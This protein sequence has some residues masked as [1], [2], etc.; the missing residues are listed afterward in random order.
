MHK[1]IGTDMSNMYT[2]YGQGGTHQLVEDK[3][4]P[5]GEDNRVERASG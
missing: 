3:R 4:V 5:E 1:G 2:L